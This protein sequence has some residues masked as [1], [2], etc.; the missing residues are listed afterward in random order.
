MAYEGIVGMRIKETRCRNNLTQAE[1]GAMLNVSVSTVSLYEN[2]K[3]APDYNLLVNI[4]DK[5][6]VTTDW[7]LGRVNETDLV[8]HEGDNIP[9]NLKEIGIEYLKLLKEIKVNEI[10]PADLKKIITAI[11]A[12]RD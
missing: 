8:L 4:A 2:N 12:I 7:L 11:K 5:F 3:R 6:N 10:P 9:F 1:F